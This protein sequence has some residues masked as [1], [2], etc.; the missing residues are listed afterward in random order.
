MFAV[1]EARLKAV[2]GLIRARVVVDRGRGVVVDASVTGDFFVYPEDC[3]FRLEEELRGA[4]VGEVRERVERALSGAKLVGSTV[5]D[6]VRVVE[7][8]V[9][10]AGWSG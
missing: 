8:A 9:R 7:E 4:P 2:K 10:A 1:G 3:V 6:F 5:E